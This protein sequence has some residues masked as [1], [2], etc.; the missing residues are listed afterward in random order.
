MRVEPKP[1]KVLEEVSR[2]IIGKG[3]VL[4][5]LWVALLSEGHVLLE[6]PP[7]VGKTLIARS[8]AQAI[9]G[10]FK[11]MQMTP[12]L[13]PAD[14]IGTTYYRISE[15]VWD[16]KYGPIFANVVLADELNR[17]TPKTQ[18]ALIEAMQEYQVTIEG[19]TLPL[20][21]P[22]IVLATQL[23]YGS[24]GTYPLT[25]VFIDRFAY[26]IE[27]E[28]PTLG[29]ELEIITRIDELERPTITQVATPEEI[30]AQVEEVRKIHVSEAV[31]RYIVDL[32]DSIRSME[33]VRLGP[34]P[35]A[36]I[37]L[38]KG[39]RALAYV[40]G[41]SYVIPDD[42]KALAKPVLMHR[43]RIKPEYEVEGVQPET[44]IGRALEGV[45][46]PKA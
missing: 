16:L 8:F 30:Q 24:E 2:L 23:P 3:D 45:E 43:I 26:K 1:S 34:S 33:E 17:A 13:L 42:I 35:R 40:E 12:D 36:S 38:Y 11:R 39:G 21:K 7:G 44:V 5:M 22:F 4:K 14:L 15:G 10:A 32:V 46:V 9:G 28:Y 25:E 20:P 29:E 37:W 27:V 18:A 41:R 6:G 19:K 31:K